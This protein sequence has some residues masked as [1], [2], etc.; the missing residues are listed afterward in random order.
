[1]K[2]LLIRH[3]IRETTD[4]ADCSISTEG[5]VLI[6]KRCDEILK[7]ITLDKNVKLLSS[8]FKRA[9]ETAMCIT[10]KFSNLEN[11]II[12]PLLHETIFNSCMSEKLSKPMMQ[13]IKME[14]SETWLDINNRCQQFL[15][16]IVKMDSDVLAVTHG[17]VLNGILTVVNPHY[18]FSKIETDPNKYIPKYADYVLLEYNDEKWTISRMNF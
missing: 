4:D 2:L 1:M 16:K 13:Y 14:S 9:I 15:N 3:S 11:I 7:Y 12:E 5:I 8:P 18:K 10:S 6:E 17:G